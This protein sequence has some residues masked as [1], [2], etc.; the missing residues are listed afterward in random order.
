MYAREVLNATDR[1][2]EYK[3]TNSEISIVHVDMAGM[4]TKRAKLDLC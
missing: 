3:H 2:A 4:G 1:K